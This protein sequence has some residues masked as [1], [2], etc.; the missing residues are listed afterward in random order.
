MIFFQ[1]LSKAYEL[2]KEYIVN[3]FPFTVEEL[4]EVSPTFNS[5]ATLQDIYDL[6]ESYSIEDVM[7]RHQH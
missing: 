7:E 5:E 1:L 2:Y 4:K 6:W 3:E